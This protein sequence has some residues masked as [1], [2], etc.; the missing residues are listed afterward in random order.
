[1]IGLFPQAG[2]ASASTRQR[3]NP[4]DPHQAARIRRAELKRFARRTKRTIREG[5]AWAMNPTISWL[6]LRRDPF[7]I[8]K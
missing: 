8:E 2:G 4:N 7:H 3:K 5:H 1:M 6:N